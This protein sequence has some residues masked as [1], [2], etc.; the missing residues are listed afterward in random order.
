MWD[1]QESSTFVGRVGGEGSETRQKLNVMQSQQGQL[2]PRSAQARAALQRCSRL[3]LGGQTPIPH[4]RQPQEG[5]RVECVSLF[6]PAVF[7]FLYE[8]CP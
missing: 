2:V 3:R 6:L 5:F 8:F 7:R 1:A 4:P